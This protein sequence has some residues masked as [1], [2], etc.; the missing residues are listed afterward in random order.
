MVARRENSARGLRITD[1][2]WRIELLSQQNFK[3]SQITPHSFNP[4]SAI[5]I[6]PSGR[7]HFVRHFSSIFLLE[8]FDPT[9]SINQF[10]FARKKWM[11]TGTNF[12]VQ[13]FLGG[14]RRPGSATGTVN[15]GVFVGGMNTSFHVVLLLKCT[16]SIIARWR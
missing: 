15:E 1:G 5:R 9:G 4:Q 2:G 12:D 10:L 16:A 6:L 8:A 13:F 14:T 3:L 11:A 7:A